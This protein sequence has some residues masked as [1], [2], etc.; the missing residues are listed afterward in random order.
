MTKAIPQRTALLFGFSVFFGLLSL[1]CWPPNTASSARPKRCIAHRDCNKDELCLRR[2]CQKKPRF[3]VVLSGVGTT[4]FH[5]AI[6]PVLWQGPIKGHP[7]EDIQRDIETQLDDNFRRLVG[8][9]R[10]LERKTFLEK[11]GENGIELGTFSFVTWQN[12][13]ANGLIKIALRAQDEK[14]LR[15]MFRYYD[16]DT[17]RQ[18]IRVNR[19]VTRD[20]LRWFLHQVC[21]DIYKKLTGQEGIFTSYI[22]YVKPNP[23]GGK[24]IWVMDF[25]GKNRRRVIS[26]GAINILPNWSPTG[27]YLTFTSF[28]EGR[29]YLYK[30]DLAT[31]QL[32][33]ISRLRGNYTGGTYAPSGQRLA[34]SIST[35]TGSDIFASDPSGNNFRRLTKTWGINISPTWSPDGKRIAFVSERFATPHIFVMNVDGSNQVRLTY[36]GEYNQEPQWSPKA[37]EI[38]FTARDEFLKY[39][40]FVIQLSTDEH[41]KTSHEYRR[42]T[43]NQGRNFEACWSPDGRFILFISTRSGPR[44]LYIMNADGSEQQPFLKIKGD[45]ESPA[46][47]PIINQQYLPDGA[48]GRSYYRRVR[49]LE[50]P[51]LQELPE[52][53]DEQG[54]EQPTRDPALPQKNSPT[55]APLSPQ[56][57][58]PLP[59]RTDI[60]APTERKRLSLRTLPPSTQPLKTSG[61]SSPTPPTRPR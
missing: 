12:I 34:F 21:N 32:S 23:K 60:S 56:P 26:N 49:M 5:L 35:K 18:E 14:H 57:A 40:L 6:A 50:G 8:M 4:A 52:S 37:S 46:W 27:R 42:L 43:Q 58:L 48:A 24:D 51:P 44:K 20:R 54:P 59:P 16:V 61:S 9:I 17:T 11:E 45:V 53:K 31:E 33:R 25:D 15:V 3:R 39:D 2:R 10:V 13:A 30:L 19:V 1:F 28:L 22:A 55:T 41:G 38:L 29:P 36:K 7:K 47:S